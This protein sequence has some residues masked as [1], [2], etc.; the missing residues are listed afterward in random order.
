[1]G[2]RQS[3]TGTSIDR[4]ATLCEKDMREAYH[5]LIDLHLRSLFPDFFHNLHA[6]TPQERERGRVAVIEYQDDEI[7]EPEIFK[8]SQDVKNHFEDPVAATQSGPRKRLFVLE[9]LSLNYVEA[10]GSRLRIPPSFFAAHW[11]DPATPAFNHRNPFRR[12]TKGSFVIRYPSTQ[13]LRVDADS[14]VHGHI[15]R[16]DFNVERHIYCYDPKGPIFDQPKS[17]HALSFWTSGI[18]EDGS[19]DCKTPLS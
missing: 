1:M 10:L 15:F 9:D 17:Y 4:S 8:N 2:E 7:P 16:C 5:E 14:E 3:P 11:A 19:W 13:P 12:Y 18:R 6:Q